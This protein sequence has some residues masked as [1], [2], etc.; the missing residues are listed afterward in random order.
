MRAIDFDD[1]RYAGRDGET[2]VVSVRPTNTVQLVTYTLEGV[3][4]PLPLG[5]TVRF[6]LQVKPG[7]APTVLQMVFDFTDNEGGSYRVGLEEVK[8]EPDDEAVYTVN[9]PPLAIRVFRFFVQ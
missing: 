8:D 3:S 2:V 9:G 5:E 4:H 7:G 1:M 6:I